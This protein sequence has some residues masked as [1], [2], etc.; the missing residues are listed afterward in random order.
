MFRTI[1]V[2]EN[3]AFLAYLSQGSRASGAAYEA[4]RGWQRRLYK[5]WLPVQ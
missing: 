3:K 1:L 2:V 5:N 4:T